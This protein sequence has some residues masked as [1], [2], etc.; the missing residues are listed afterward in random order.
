MIYWYYPPDYKAYLNFTE[1]V[2][3]EIMRCFEAEGIEFAFP[4]TTN[5]LAHDQRRPLQISI[6]SASQLFKPNDAQPPA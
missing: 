1:Q 2:Y 6:E 3:L 4:T 5:Y